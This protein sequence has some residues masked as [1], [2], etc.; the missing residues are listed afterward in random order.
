M[1]ASG[2]TEKEST[3]S[4]AFQRETAL[5]DLGRVWMGPVLYP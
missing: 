5:L 1:W 4:R 3:K 2:L